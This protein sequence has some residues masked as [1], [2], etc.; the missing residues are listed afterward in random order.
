[1]LKLLPLLGKSIKEL[2]L[3]D[4][5][6]VKSALNID[7]DLTDELHQAALALLQGESIDTVSDLI[8][9]PESIQKLLAL[10]KRQEAVP[11]TRRIVKCNHCDNFMLVD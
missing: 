5:M 10:L 9:S 3:D 11:P 8:K 2:T 1:M 7:V 4:L 6:L